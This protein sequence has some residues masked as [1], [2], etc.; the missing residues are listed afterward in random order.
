MDGASLSTTTSVA[1]EVESLTTEPGSCSTNEA[2]EN[3]TAPVHGDDRNNAF[4][5]GNPVSVGVAPLQREEARE[6]A[7]AAGGGERVGEGAERA[8]GG[9]VGVGEASKSEEELLEAAGTVLDGL[10][11]DAEADEVR[12]GRPPPPRA[13]VVDPPPLRSLELVGH[14]K[15]HSASYSFS[16]A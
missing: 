3:E 10:G 4:V 11:G 2:F 13:V 15:R 1:G 6:D 8:G 14:C 7:S 12:K 5:V 9:G 16:W